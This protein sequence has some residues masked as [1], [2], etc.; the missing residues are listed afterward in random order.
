MFFFIWFLQFDDGYQRV[1]ARIDSFLKNI[2][3]GMSNQTFKIP[4]SEYIQ[5]YKYVFHF[6]VL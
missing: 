1:K 3:E 5:I 6:I 4:S 2:E